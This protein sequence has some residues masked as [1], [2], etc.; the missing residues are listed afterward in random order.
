[1]SEP[2]W[3]SGDSA[4]QTA[5]ADC[6][7]ELECDCSWVGEVAASDEYRNGLIYWWTDWTCPSCGESH[8]SEG[9][10]EYFEEE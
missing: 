4:A 6:V 8:H 5:I 9:E 7:R 2:M 3:M 1:M 10:Y